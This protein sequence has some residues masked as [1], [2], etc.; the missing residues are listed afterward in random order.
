MSF[1]GDTVR[2]I[3]GIVQQILFLYELAIIIVIALSWVNPDPY[4]PIV[5]ALHSITDPVMDRVRGL[6]PPIGMLDLTPMVIILLIEFIRSI[7][8]PHLANALIAR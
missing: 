4:N 2:F 7:A 6:I 3:L 8:L 1:A 5:R